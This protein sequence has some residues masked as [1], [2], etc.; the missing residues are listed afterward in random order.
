ML[1]H[2]GRGPRAAVGSRVLLLGAVV[3][4]PSVNLEG[5]EGDESQ[6]VLETLHIVLPGADDEPPVPAD[7]PPA[8]EKPASE[9]PT[10]EKPVDNGAPPAKADESAAPQ[11]PE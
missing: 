2:S 11:Q 5:Y 10:D 1:P 8:D 6:I 4:D 7:K 3:A 9:K